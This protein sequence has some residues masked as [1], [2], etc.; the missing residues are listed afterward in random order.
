MDV[1]SLGDDHARSLGMNTGF[2]RTLFLILSAAMAGAAVCV[3]GLLSFVGLMVP[4]AVRRAATNESRH[5]IPLCALFGAGYAGKQILHQV[6]LAIPENKVTVILGPNGCGKSTL[7]KTLCGIVP[8]QQGQIRLHGEDLLRLK[9][10]DKAKR[11]SYLAQGQQLPH[12]TAYA[13]V[14]Q[15]RFP[16]VRYPFRYRKSDHGRAQAAMEQ[17]GIWGHRNALME[18]LSGGQ[19]QKVYIAMAL[20]QD[21]PEEVYASGTPEAVFPVRLCRSRTPPG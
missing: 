1:L 16:H 6:D 4:H 2:M 3:A 9:P 17:M 18:E 5:L 11:I 10:K 14:L 20:T 21:T 15:G 13:L 12:I 19:R 7:L 8:V